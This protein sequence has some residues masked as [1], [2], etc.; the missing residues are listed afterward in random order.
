MLFKKYFFELN[1]SV[2]AKR[3]NSN[4]IKIKNTETN[5]VETVDITDFIYANTNGGTEPVTVYGV[6]LND[7]KTD[8]T[9]KAGD[10]MVIN[11]RMTFEYKPTGGKSP[12]G[13]SLVRYK[14]YNLLT[15]EV[16]SVDGQKYSPKNQRH[17]NVN[18]ITKI[19]M[20]NETYKILR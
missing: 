16:K 18:T 2:N 1:E 15:L 13:D 6:R 7:S 11:G 19:V 12:L 3:I 14:H 10:K 20:G 9:K 4:L 8:P 17:I 5:K